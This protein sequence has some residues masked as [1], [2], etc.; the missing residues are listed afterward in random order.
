MDGNN[1]ALYRASTPESAQMPHDP[2]RLT[3]LLATHQRQFVRYATRRLGN[4]ADAEDVVQ[5]FNLKV[6]SRAEG[7]AQ[8]KGLAWLYRVLHTTLIDHYRREATRRRALDGLARELQVA[9][10]EPVATPCGCVQRVLPTLRLDQQELLRRADLGSEPHGQI[11]AS[12]GT[13]A[14]AIGVRL[15]R[16]R[17]VLRDSLTRLCGVCCPAEAMACGCEAVADEIGRKDSSPSAFELM[18]AGQ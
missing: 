8:P 13:T 15:H 4:R 16:A 1:K 9:E 2:G 7:A 6:L 11:A 17:R 10:A 14:N 12:L 5:S 3:T 18:Q